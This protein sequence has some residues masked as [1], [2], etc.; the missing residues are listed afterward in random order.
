MT[1]KVM[2]P[3]ITQ[4]VMPATRATTGSGLPGGT[5]AS[6]VAQTASGSTAVA[7]ATRRHAWRR[8]VGRRSRFTYSSQ[9]STKNSSSVTRS[10]GSL[11]APVSTR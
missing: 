1:P 11:T 2:K 7:T 4:L 10:Q 6:R 3:V 8:K 5:N 9:P